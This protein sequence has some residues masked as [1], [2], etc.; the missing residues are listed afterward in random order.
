[1]SLIVLASEQKSLEKPVVKQQLDFYLKLLKGIPYTVYSTVPEGEAEVLLD[2]AL[3]LNK[4]TVEPDPL[5][6]IISLGDTQARN[7]TYYRNNIVHLF[8]VPSL[9]VTMVLKQSSP[10]RNAIVEFIE[11]V[12][13]LLQTELFVE[14]PDLNVYINQS[15]DLMLDE[16]V[17]INQDGNLVASEQH[18]NQLH[19]LA[20]ICSETLIRYAIIFNLLSLQPKVERSDLERE[21][22]QLAKHMGTLHGITAPEFYDKKLYATLTVKLKEMDLIG[23]VENNPDVVQLSRALTSLLEAQVRQTVLTGVQQ[24]QNAEKESRS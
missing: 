2:Q 14:T 6:D 20:N 19:L 10:S 12:F 1:M 24:T 8:M 11:Q 13:P 4:F 17:L 21:S 18:L 9:I 16:N 15:I 7:M 3:D 22:H 5:G 23:K